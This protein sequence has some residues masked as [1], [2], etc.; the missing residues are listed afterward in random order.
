MI[1]EAIG[2]VGTYVEAP[3][4]GTHITVDYNEGFYS[5][6]KEGSLRKVSVRKQNG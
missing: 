3:A 2:I 5:A 4:D 6:E 1:A